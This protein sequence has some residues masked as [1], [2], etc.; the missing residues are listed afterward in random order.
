MGIAFE[1]LAQSAVNERFHGALQE[2]AD[3]LMTMAAEQMM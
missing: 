3:R 1:N 2:S